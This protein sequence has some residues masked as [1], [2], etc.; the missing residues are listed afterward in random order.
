MCMNTYTHVSLN[1]SIVFVK[2]FAKD[3]KEGEQKEKKKKKNFFGQG[4]YTGV[5]VTS[6][7]NKLSWAL[8]QSWERASCLEQD[9]IVPVSKKT[10]W[11]QDLCSHALGSTTVS[12]ALC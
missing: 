8:K 11:L 12:R 7:K 5:Q 4:H 9:Q 3:L 6:D 2:V 1:I 10:T